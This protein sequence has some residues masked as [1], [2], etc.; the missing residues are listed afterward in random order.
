MGIRVEGPILNVELKEVQAA[1]KHMKSQKA[2][3]PTS[4]FI[5][6]LK[7]GDERCFKFLTNIFN[8]MLFKN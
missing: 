5:K 8:A 6:M 4:V 3:E 7:T 1:R 2:N